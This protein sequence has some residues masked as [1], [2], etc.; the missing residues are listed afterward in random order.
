MKKG[1]TLLFILF[2]Y[3]IGYTQTVYSIKN[4]LLKLK[5]TT[6]ILYVAA[7]PDDENNL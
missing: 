4:D 7:H 5:N 6:T 3:Q 2:F 1:I